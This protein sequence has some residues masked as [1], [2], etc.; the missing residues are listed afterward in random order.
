MKTITIPKR[1]GYPTLDITVNGEEQTFASGVEISVEDYVA[2]AIENAIALAPK[3]GRNISRI[4]QVV[5]GSIEEVTPYDLEGIE[6]IRVS[7]FYSCKDL[8]KATIP[9]N[10][11]T[12]ESY[13]FYGCDNMESITMGN[14]LTRIFP[15]AFDGCAKL[16]SVHLPKNPPS[17]TNVNAFANINASC[18][19]SC[20]SQESL[21]SYKKA[22]NWSTLTG[23]YTF[24]VESK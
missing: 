11:N 18:V 22:A 17:L 24:V 16:T 21:E 19:F 23:T 9:N 2:E 12:I 1:L 15:S 14:G 10:I 8:K 7:A 6:K 13:A 20:K 4:S 5:G 3:L